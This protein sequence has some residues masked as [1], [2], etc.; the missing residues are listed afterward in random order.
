M[1]KE[2]VDR[3]LAKTGSKNYSRLSLLA[4][5]YFD[6]ERAFNVP[7][8]CF[9]PK[10]RVNSSVVKLIFRKS[11]S[12]VDETLLFQII[13]YTFAHRRKNILNSLSHELKNQY[14]K[15]TVEKAL[16]KAGLD[17]KKRAEDLSMKD[18]LKLTEAFRKCCI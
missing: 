16:S 8:T 12:N 17:P 6:I 4:Q 5:Y 10:P 7:R 13:K 11:D 9:S 18:Y 14:S 3:L 2:I 1:Q 15:E